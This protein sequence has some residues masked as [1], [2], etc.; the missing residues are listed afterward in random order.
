MRIVKFVLYRYSLP[1]K[2]PVKIGQT[3]ID[4]R[5]GLILEIADKEG[6]S[7]LGEL[8]PLPGFSSESLA[9]AEKQI[10]LFI[11]TQSKNYPV[12]ITEQS[13]NNLFPSVRFGMESAMLHLLAE[14]RETTVSKVLSKNSR[15]DISINGLL[16]GDNKAKLNKAALYGKNGYSALKLKVGTLDLEYDIELTRQVRTAAGEN[17]KLR[18]DANRCW[19]LANAQKFCDAVKDCEIEYLE[20]PLAEPNKL[21]EAVKNE[22]FSVPIAMDETTREVL[23]F[24]LSNYIGIKAIVL[25]PTL[26]GVKRTLEFAE[27]A[28]ELGI[29]AVIGSSFESSLGLSFLAQLAA[30]VNQE[31]IPAGLDTYDW[32]A[33][34]IIKGSLPVRN[35]RLKV[36][37]LVDPKTAIQ[38]GLLELVE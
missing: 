29:M 1:L 19:D 5:D 8:A 35:G 33:D 10:S 16:T 25:K 30:A 9:E 18:L 4:R 31:D 15:Q 32:F 28:K 34:D 12:D 26:L 13:F 23:P 27:K 3:T 21:M 38:S 20:E 7:G 24:G 11:S 14:S 36:S 37:D 6:R 22:L 17:V 2:L